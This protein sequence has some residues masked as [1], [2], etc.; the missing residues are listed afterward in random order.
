MK[1]NPSGSSDIGLAHQLFGFALNMSE[2]RAYR[3]SHCGSV[4]RVA[5]VWVPGTPPTA[6]KDFNVLTLKWSFKAE[7][8]DKLTY[9]KGDKGATCD[10]R[11]GSCSESDVNVGS[12][13]ALNVNQL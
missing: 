11:D 8:R 13:P 3:V 12:R 7:H 1:I 2:A 10:K 4:A 6:V 5:E 9:P